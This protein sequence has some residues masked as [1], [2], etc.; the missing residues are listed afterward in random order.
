MNPI[1]QHTILSL[2]ML[3]SGCRSTTYLWDTRRQKWPNAWVGE[4]RKST[5][6]VD[7]E[8]GHFMRVRV[9]IDLF[10]PLCRG[11]VIILED[12]GKFWVSFK[13]ER[14]PNLCYWCG[15]LNHDDK[16]CELWIQSKDTLKIEDQQFKSKLRATPYTSTRKDFIF[17]PGYY[18]NRFPR[19]QETPSEK[20]INQAKEV[21]EAILKRIEQP[22]MEYERCGDD[23]NDNCASNS[24]SNL[25]MEGEKLAGEVTT[26]LIPTLYKSTI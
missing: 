10:L 24:N 3:R 20:V 22:G 19:R 15:W 16:N 5:G 18:K 26:S 17:V 7:K 14:L 9:T 2:N 4:V 23:F 12:G 13:Y 8:G 25:Q 11:R 21:T 1:P 6:V